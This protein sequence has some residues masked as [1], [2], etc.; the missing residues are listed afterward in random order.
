MAWRSLAMAIMNGRWFVCVCECC[1]NKCQSNI[2]ISCLADI[3][4]Q[5]RIDLF[6]YAVHLGHLPSF[7][8]LCCC[9]CYLS[10]LLFDIRTVVVRIHT[11]KLCESIILI[12]LK[13]LA[14]VHQLRTVLGRML[15]KVFGGSICWLLH[16]GQTFVHPYTSKRRFLGYNSSPAW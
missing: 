6:S 15:D 16:F 4:W 5:M 13:S 14:K 1:Y 3:T 8:W 9:R 12:V 2:L 7:C 10:A 11:H